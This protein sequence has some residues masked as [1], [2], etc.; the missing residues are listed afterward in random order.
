MQKWV[1]DVEFVHVCG[2]S[3]GVPTLFW[4]KRVIKDP[5]Y[6]NTFLTMFTLGLIAVHVLF[7]VYS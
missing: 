5:P 7:H 3:E 2:Q 1:S 6:Y 4:G